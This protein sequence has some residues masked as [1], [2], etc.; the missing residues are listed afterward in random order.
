[1]KDAEYFAHPALG[2]TSIKTMATGTPRSYWAKHVDPKRELFVPTEAMRQGSLVD[3]LITCPDEFDEKYVLMPLDAP[4]RPTVT[5][6]NAKK[7]SEA[8]IE[9]IQFW[10]DFQSGLRG[11]EVLSQEWLTT[12]LQIVDTLSTDATIGPILKMERQSQVPHFWDDAIH[13]IACK[14]KPDLEPSDGSLLDL[15]KG[16]TAKPSL[17][18]RQA[19]SLGYD[20]QIDHYSKGFA[21]LHGKP[22]TRC[23]FVVYEW[24]YP[25]DCALIIVDDA[26]LEL[27]RERRNSAITKIV[28]C[29]R[30]GEYPS[31]GETMI[32]RPK[33]TLT[34]A[35]DDEGETDFSQEI[36]L[37]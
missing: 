25:H 35:P 22:P 4:K 8:T 16:A 15:K 27:G 33:F 24:K 1:V 17:F 7:P 28:E 18:E 29:E 5:Q 11:R 37:F 12:A 23:G 21:D 36:E 13:S 34:S 20:I 32:T 2:S 6:I 19:F 14:Y 30:T 26:Y 31:Y 3:C 10:H 9:A